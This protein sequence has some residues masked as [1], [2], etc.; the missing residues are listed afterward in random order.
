VEATPVPTIFRPS[1]NAWPARSIS[2]Q[3]ESLAGQLAVARVIV[4]RS[5]SGRYPASYCGVVYQPSQ[6]SFVRGHTMPAINHASRFWANAARIAVIA[7]Q[8]SW[9]SPVEG[10]LFFHAR[11]FRRPGARPAWPRSAGTCSTAEQR[12]T[13]RVYST[14]PARPATSLTYCQATRPERLPRRFDHSSASPGL[15][16]QAQV[17]AIA[18]DDRQV[19]V[20]VAGVESQRQAEAVGQGQPV[21]HR[22]ARI[23]RIVLLA[24]VALDDGAAV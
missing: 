4:A 13:S 17:R 1:W 5:Q 18:G 3:S 16:R 21:V 24:H 10:A 2:G 23:D 9:K 19:I 6:F 12:G 11:A 22:V 15:E 14:R 7:D 20:L 8:G